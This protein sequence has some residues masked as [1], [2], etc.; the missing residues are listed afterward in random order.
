MIDTVDVLDPRS[1]IL[2]PISRRTSARPNLHELWT[3]RTNMRLPVVHLLI[4]QKS[5]RRSFKITS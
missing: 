3:K 1:G 2:G 4:L 5:G